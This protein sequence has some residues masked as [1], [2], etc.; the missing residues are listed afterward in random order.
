MRESLRASGFIGVDGL[1][2][3]SDFDFLPDDSTGRKFNRHRYRLSR[4]KAQIV[5]RREIACY[6]CAES[7]LATFH[8]GKTKLALRIGGGLLFDRR[9]SGTREENLN[10]S[11]WRSRIVV[12]CTFHGRLRDA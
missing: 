1:I 6:F 10:A 4:A 5:A 7:V 12:D 9:Q 2:L 8:A 11:D 3:G